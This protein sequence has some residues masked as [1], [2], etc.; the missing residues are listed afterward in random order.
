[1][2]LLRVF[3]FAMSFD[4]SWRFLRAVVECNTNAIMYT[5]GKTAIVQVPGDLLKVPKTMA[6]SRADLGLMVAPVYG[7]VNVSDT[8]KY[9]HIQQL[10]NGVERI[11]NVMFQIPFPVEEPATG[12]VRIDMTEVPK[13]EPKPEPVV[14]PRRKRTPRLKV[15]P[16]AP[17]VP[18]PIQ[19][20]VPK[21]RTPKV[22]KELPAAT[23]PPKRV[24]KKVTPPEPQA[25]AQETPKRRK[26]GIK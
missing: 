2:L 22:E 13:E 5:D 26:R 21:K 15:E 23:E 9:W 8:P 18:E 4:D 24:R 25:P 20:P 6:E 17:P 11:D 3:K 16:E 10:S 12:E 7:K 14:K 1:M 19:K